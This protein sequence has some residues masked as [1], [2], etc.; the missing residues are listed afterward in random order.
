MKGI[1]TVMAKASY[2]VNTLGLK[3]GPIH[4]RLLAYFNEMH[5]AR[6]AG[7]TQTIEELEVLVPQ[8]LDEFE[9]TEC[10]NY[11]NPGWLAGKMRGGWNLARGELY[12][13]LQAELTG[14]RY[15]DEEPSAPDGNDTAKK[16]RKS[17]SASNIA[18]QLW[19]MGRAAEGLPWAQ[20]SVELWPSNSINY[21][22]LGITA[23]HGGLKKQAD[24]IFRN[25]RQVANFKDDQ[26]VIAKCMEFERELHT[27]IDLPTV[28]D[29]L[30]DMGVK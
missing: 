26:D 3:V 19:R 22:V 17:V 10:R 11:P 15:A 12:A 5:E 1:G 6:A 28:K 16:R 21:L 13:A 23:Y 29:L 27:M 20:L 24:Q 14:F 7:D 18:D 30:E 9:S 2:E 4:E 25:L 8:L